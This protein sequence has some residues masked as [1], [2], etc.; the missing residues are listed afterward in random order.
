MEEPGEKEEGLVVEDDEPAVWLSGFA[1]SPLGDNKAREGLEPSVEEVVVGW[2]DGLR[3]GF[4]SLAND[5]GNDDDDKAKAAPLLSELLASNDNNEEEERPV[6][7]LPSPG[8]LT[9]TWS[10]S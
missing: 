7:S 1:P 5:E 3:F 2:V 10:W 8:G 9:S 6:L 4:R